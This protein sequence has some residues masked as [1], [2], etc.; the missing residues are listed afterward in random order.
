MI[1]I[2]IQGILNTEVVII[3]KEYAYILYRTF[4]NK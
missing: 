3:I 2:F 4:G 1:W